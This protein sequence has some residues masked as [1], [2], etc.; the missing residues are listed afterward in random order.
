MKNENSPTFLWYDYETFGAQTKQDRISQFAAVRTDMDLNI[1]GEPINL[2]CKPSGDCI[3]DPMACLITRISPQYA[4]EHGLIE[5]DFAA[6]INQIMSE[7]NTCVVGYNSIRFDDEM[8]RFLF[9]R[10]FYDAY[11]REWKNGN[12]RWDLLDVSRLY[13][14]L[15]PEGIHWPV[16]EDGSPSFK[17]EELTKANGIEHLKAHDA[18][19]DVLAT[20]EFAKLLKSKQP[21]MFE[22]AFG[23]RNKHKVAAQLDVMS[24]KPVVHISGMFAA[25][26]GCLSTVMPLMVHPTNKNEIICFDLQHSPE[27]LLNLNATDLEKRMFT[28]KDQLVA[29]NLL[30]AGL[31]SIHLNRSPMIGPLSLLT[32]EVCERLSIERVKQ[33]DHFKALL[34]LVNKVKP[35]LREI[36]S[37]EFSSD[38]EHAQA[39]YGGA[40]F[41][42]NDKRSMTNLH[43]Q[44]AQTVNPMQWQFED[45]RL[46]TLL[47][48]WLGRNYFDEVALDVQKRW[49]EYCLQGLTDEHIGSARTL[50]QAKEYCDE[51]I[52]IASDDNKTDQT[53]FLLQIKSYLDQ[54]ESKI[55]LG[56]L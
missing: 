54:L 5:Q 44:L 25:Q 56:Q 45:E 49:T 29:D 21:K 50:V 32:V 7:P 43:K 34:P 14:A 18:V 40:F 33:E 26:N 55:M 19:S 13:Y 1:I 48:Q 30:P 24:F 53:T 6:T 35:K 51:L 23:L 37:K 27:P 8:T 15:R 22:Y 4:F 36:F 28:K 47:W 11:E 20:I 31:K 42:N 39:L 10:N 3:P 38:K 52:Q 17:L 16:K 2:F 41:N 46:N 9:Y 12:S